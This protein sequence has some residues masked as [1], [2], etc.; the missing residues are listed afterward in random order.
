[1]FVNFPLSRILRT[2][3][4]MIQL[5]L[6]S[7]LLI[8]FAGKI[9][10]GKIVIYK[11]YH[12]ILHCTINHNKLTYNKYIFYLVSFLCNIWVKTFNYINILIIRNFTSIR[13][14]RHPNF[15]ENKSSKWWHPIIK[16]NDKSDN[17]F[18]IDPKHSFLSWFAYTC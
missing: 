8:S 3:I 16:I 5:H 10:L 7:L 9:V 12:P 13:Q 18:S 17:S 4:R 6:F 14:T 15:I 11:G 1:M 2:W